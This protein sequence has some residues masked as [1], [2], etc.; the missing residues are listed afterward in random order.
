MKLNHWSRWAALGALALTAGAPRSSSAATTPE[1]VPGQVVVGFRT[2]D[3]LEARAN[4]AANGVG[5]VLGHQRKLRATRLRLNRGMSLDAALARLRQRSDVAYAEPVYILRAF[6][7]PNDPSYNRQWSLPKIQADRAWELWQP[8]S[9]ITL[10]I[11]DTGIDQSHPDLANVLLRDSSGNV[12]GYNAQSN[13]ATGSAASDDNGHG[14]HCAGTA[15]GQ[16]NNTKGIAGVAGW[17]PGVPASNSYVQLMPVKVLDADGSGTD[18]DV[19]EG[20]IWATDHGARV[21]SMSLGGAGSSTTLSNAVSYARSHGVV[22]VAAAGNE[23]TSTK[24]YPAAYTGVISVA[25]TDSNDTLAYF[26]NYGTW[27]KVAAPGVSI[28]NTYKGSSYAT[29]SGTSM[30]TPH[31]A[32]EAAA[33]LAQNPSLSTSQ[34]E[35]LIV[36]NVDPYNPYNGL[37]IGAGAG[38]INV[39][40][41]LLAAGGGASSVS[42]SSLTLSPTSVQGGGSSTATVT[43]TG[44]APTGGTQVSVYSDSGVASVPATVTVPAGQSSATFTVSTAS[45]SS[46]TSAQI[47]ATVGS[48]SRSATLQIT[49]PAAMLTLNSVSVSPSSIAS[50]ATATGTVVL[51]GAAPVGGAVVSL[52]SGNTAVATVA[53]SVTVPAGSTSATF[54]VVAKTVSANTAV[55]LYASYAGA[56]RTT[57]LTVTKPATVIA[58]SS[59][60]LNP[61]AVVGGSGST[62]T[63]TLNGA[64]PSGG[65]VVTLSDNSASASVPS[66]VTVPAGA[67]S[68]TFTVSTTAVSS[69]TS[70]TI[71]GSY[72]GAT[73]TA[74]L[75]ITAPD[76]TLKLTLSASSVRGG[77]SVTGTV[78]LSSRAPSG[79]VIVTLSSSSSAVYVPNSLL[80]PEGY[81][82]R[83]FAIYTD[84]VSVTTTAVITATASGSTTSATLTVRPPSVTKVKLSPAKVKAGGTTTATVYLDTEAPTGGVPVTVTCTSSAASAPARVTVPAG[85]RKVSFKV[86]TS[87][88]VSTTVK[89][90]ASTGDGSTSTSLKILGV[91]SSARALTST[92]WAR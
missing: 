27:V 73:R 35:S 51:S 78:S 77:Y 58:L 10:A 60:T 40:K 53:S 63:V 1:I 91:K 65:A 47:T 79:G 66:S 83:R 30:A 19:S 80:I 68:A 74:T 36:G 70:A 21:I 92:D 3:S 52:T 5:L 46:G 12:I 18:A 54:A 14:T 84:P 2:S 61:T 15:A 72:G 45:V 89:V 33:I 50:G 11:I 64:A 34:V 6:S 37:T 41:A 32:G 43:L 38:R 7:T 44:T 9:K 39:Y 57:T 17:N 87:G 26:S 23:S 90:S 59:V 49:A 22:V 24:S 20:I 25:A 67:T 28:Y 75:G 8:Q 88:R 31:V 81:S 85:T 29:M 76:T 16:I 86:R 13:Q 71:T 69:S 42:L 55:T 48:A 56:T 4:E 82:G 62:G